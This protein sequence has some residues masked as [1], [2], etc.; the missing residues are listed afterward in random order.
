MFA[1]RLGSIVGRRLSARTLP[2]HRYLLS[3]AFQLNSEWS[4]RQE[5]LKKLALGGDYEWIAAVQKKFIG[6]GHASAVDVDAAACGA[7]EKDQIEDIVDLIYKLRHTENAA[8]LLE[9]TEYAV[10]RMLLKNDAVEKLFLVLND[11]INYG[12][13]L[14][15][16]SASLGMD[17]FLTKENFAAAA[18]IATFVMLQEMLDNRLVNLLSVYSCLKWLELPAEE[19]VFSAEIHPQPDVEE[20]E[21]SEEDQKT[22]KFPYLKNEFFDNHFDLVEPEALVGKTLLWVSQHLSDAALT[23]NLRIL[24]ALFYKQWELLESQL[25]K[26]RN[27][28]HDVA[29]ICGERIDQLLAGLGEGQEESPEAQRY[30]KLKELVE[31]TPKSESP[32]KLSAIVEKSFLAVREDEEKSLTASQT[33][34]FKKWNE[35][36]QSLIEAQAQKVALRIRLEEIAEEKLEAEEE[37]ERL[38]FFENREMWLD[39][40]YERD[41]LFEEL[42]VDAEASQQTEQQ[43][44]MEMFEKARKFVEQA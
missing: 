40:A 35:R 7:E 28:T 21:I 18:K 10:V 32:E 26:S 44:S 38:M 33:A 39:K 14:N 12:I 4:H 34:L 30:N 3:S 31:K 37:K 8:D 1:T 42:K 2:S 5:A 29:A 36:R 27:L 41:R 25:E 23:E 17:Y 6:G 22:F 19:R 43:Y 11:P 9:S 20:E 24:G 15:E 13:F 16:H